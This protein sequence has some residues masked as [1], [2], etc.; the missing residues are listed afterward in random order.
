MK[1]PRGT[2]VPA[3]VTE[4][5]ALLRGDRAAA[6]RLAGRLLQPLNDNFVERP[7]GGVGIH[8]FKQSKAP[9]NAR[10]GEA[11]EISA[12]DS[13][14]EARRYPSTIRLDDGSTLTLP[15]LLAVH[16]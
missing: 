11:F 14:D 10:I 12:D 9:A 13:D 8:A 3:G 2:S 16:G 7:W 5:Q 4:A 6:V 15:A 1:R